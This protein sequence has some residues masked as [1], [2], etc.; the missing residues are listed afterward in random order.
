VVP[1]IKGAAAHP[2]KLHVAVDFYVRHIRAIMA[3]LDLARVEAATLHTYKVLDRDCMVDCLGSRPRLHDGLFGNKAPT[4]EASH[5]AS[6]RANTKLCR[7]SH[8][9]GCGRRVIF[10]ATNPRL[11]HPFAQTHSPTVRRFPIF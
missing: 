2:E 1:M 9:T 11:C 5:P 3:N 8:M 10:S 7:S 4:V 6:L